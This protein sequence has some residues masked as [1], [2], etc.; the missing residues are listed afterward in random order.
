MSTPHN[1][2]KKGAFAKVVLMPGDPLRSKYIVD[3]FLKD[4]ELVNNVR[5]IQGY[6]GFTKNGKRVSVMA[7]GM[8]MP[9]IGVYSNELFKEYDVDVILRIGTAGSYRKEVEVGEIVLSEGACTNS[10]WASQ[11]D[12]RGGTYSAIASFDV[13]LTAY[14]IGQEQGKVVHCGNT[15]SSDIFYDVDPTMWKRWADMGVM[16]V[17]MEAYALYSNA[18]KLGKKALTILTISDSFVSDTILTPEE[19]QTGLNSMIELAI[20]VAEKYA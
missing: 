19:R 20:A 10:N 4:A 2:A 18:A 16:A 6:T 9:S 13:L 5:G 7:S 15:L 17:E 11:Y 14:Q 12:L 1:A 3:T 8:G